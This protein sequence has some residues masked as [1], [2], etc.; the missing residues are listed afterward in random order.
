MATSKVRK[1]EIKDVEEMAV[2][3][4]DQ[5]RGNER[6]LRKYKNSNGEIVPEEKVGSDIAVARVALERI[7]ER[8]SV[9]FWN[10]DEIIV[11][12][13]QYFEACEIS[14]TFPSLM[15]L[16]AKGFGTYRERLDTF[17]ANHPDT[18]T[19]EYIGIVKELMADILTNASLRNK[20]NVAQ[21]IFQLKNHFG[22]SD[23]VKVVKTTQEDPLTMGTKSEKEILERYRQSVVWDD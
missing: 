10:I 11:R 20:A 1:E 16:C 13:E 19:A 5:Q 9:D 4:H 8:G 14:G 6:A 2:E 3:I 7:R 18:P 17:I 21:T 22:H 15:G 23:E 12:T